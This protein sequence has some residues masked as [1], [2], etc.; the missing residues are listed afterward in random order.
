[1]LAYVRDA[2]GRYP[3]TEEFAHYIDTHIDSAFQAEQ[4]RTA[5]A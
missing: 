2:A 1:M 5:A 3:D 4:S